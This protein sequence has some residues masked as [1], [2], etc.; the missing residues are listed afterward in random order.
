MRLYAHASAQKTL[1]TSE[2]SISSLT[3]MIHFMPDMFT[4]EAATRS[5]FHASPLRVFGFSEIATSWLLPPISKKLTPARGR[6]LSR[7]AIEAPLSHA[8]IFASRLSHHGGRGLA[9]VRGAAASTDAAANGLDTNVELLSNGSQANSAGFV[10]S[11]D[12]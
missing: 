3:A 12:G 6:R 1:S 5:A 8:E 7:P 10:G 4:M 9:G 11:A 2:M